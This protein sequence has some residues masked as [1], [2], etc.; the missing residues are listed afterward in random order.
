VNKSLAVWAIVAVAA[1]TGL[2]SLWRGEKMLAW[3]P[4]P[5][6]G[7]AGRIALAVAFTVAAVIFGLVAQSVY[8][9]MLIN[10]PDS[11]AR[12]YLWIGAGAAVVLTVAAIIVTMILKRGPIIA[13]IL[14][15]FLWGIGYGWGLPAL[16]A[17]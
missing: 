8:G 3:Y 7:I 10:R 5:L 4:I 14:L 6:P 15:N 12:I 17:R 16:L 9:R 1:L 11:A 13:W 2:V